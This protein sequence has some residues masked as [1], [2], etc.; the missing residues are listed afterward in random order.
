M[1]AVVI[2]PGCATI[3][4]GGGQNMTVASTPAGASCVV[5][6]AGERLGTVAPTPGQL[7]LDKSKNDLLVTC[8]KEG[9]LTVAQPT[10]P[11]FI[12]TTFYNFIIGGGV[13]FIV[14]A[15]SGANFKYP[16]EINVPLTPAIAASPAMPDPAAGGPIVLRPTDL[17]S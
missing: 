13:G 17:R 1:L 9:Y 12:G 3:I 5:D 11:R 6:R 7:R 15:A 8:S 14:D 10:K 2:L 16:S 4:E